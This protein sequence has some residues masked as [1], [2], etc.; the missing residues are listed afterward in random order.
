MVS[1][2]KGHSTIVS[3]SLMTKWTK[4]MKWINLWNG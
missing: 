1:V 4:W 3:P 2:D